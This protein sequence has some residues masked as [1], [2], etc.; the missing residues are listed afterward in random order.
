MKRKSNWGTVPVRNDILPGA[1]KTQISRLRGVLCFCAGQSD[2]SS[3]EET[4]SQGHRILCSTE[5]KISVT[6]QDTA[7]V[8]SDSLPAQAGYRGSNC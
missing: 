2:V 5:Y 6:P 7:S 4:A 3:A 1:P 8:R